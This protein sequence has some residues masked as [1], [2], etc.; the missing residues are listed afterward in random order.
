MAARLE[1]AGFESL[2]VS[3]HIVLPAVDRVA[4]PLRRR[5]PRDLAVDDAVRRRP[6]RAGADGRGDRARD[7]RDGG[8]RAAA[9]ASGR[10][11]EAGGVDRRRQRRAAPAR[12]RRGL[13]ARGVRRPRRPVRGSRPPARGVDG[14]R[15]RLLDR[16]PGRPLERALHAPGGRALPADAGAADPVPDGRPLPRRAAA[17][18]PAGRRAGSPSSRSSELDPDA[19]AARGRTRCAP[20]PRR[21]AAIPTTPRV[22]LRLVDSAGRADEI[23]RRASRPRGGRRRRDHR[24]RRLGRRGRRGPVHAG[25]AS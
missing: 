22:V 10:L 6:D 7:A 19:L 5:R 17:R 24:Q 14:D 21:R 13:A 16:H 15:P 1:A 8:A 11:R 12:R 23:A 4:L 25:C 3:D 18:G 2:W 20:R 9:P